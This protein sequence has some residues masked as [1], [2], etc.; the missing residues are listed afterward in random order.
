MDVRWEINRVSTPERILQKI[1]EEM[2]QPVGIVLFGADNDLKD[3]IY[4]SYADRLVKPLSLGHFGYH[5]LLPD[6]SQEKVYLDL[7]PVKCN[8]DCRILVMMAGDASVDHARRH[9]VVTVLREL[10]MK[11]VV[12]IYA[13]QRRLTL[14]AFLSDFKEAVRITKQLKILRR[15]PPTPDGLDY[16]LIARVERRH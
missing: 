16:L 15:N 8:G 13:Q 3:R 4:R 11:T 5:N 10:G 7:E 2:P 1:N 12:G 14:R 9:Q 6:W